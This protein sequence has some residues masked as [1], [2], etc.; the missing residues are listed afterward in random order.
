MMERVPLMALVMVMIHVPLIFLD[1]GFDME[2]FRREIQ[3]L[4]N[5]FR[6]ISL[7]MK[8]STGKILDFIFE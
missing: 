6:F 7:E 1:V 3:I 5:N 2:K 8:N 4:P